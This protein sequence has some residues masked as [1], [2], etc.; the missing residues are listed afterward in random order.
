MTV[1]YEEY[2]EMPH[3]F[4]IWT[5]FSPTLSTSEWPQSKM[6][7]ARWADACNRLGRGQA[8]EGG[9]EVILTQGG[10]K[11]LDPKNLVSVDHK[12]RLAAMKEKQAKWQ[13][14]VGSARS[15]L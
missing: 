9:A 2:E 11:S 5:T 14:F 15:H 4:P 10:R 7:M 3:V 8:I 1:R 6:A 12:Q 13:P